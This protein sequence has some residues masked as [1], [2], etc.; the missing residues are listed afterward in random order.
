MEVIHGATESEADAQPHTLPVQLPAGR[1]FDVGSR[2]PG[3][4]LV[5]GH[6]RVVDGAA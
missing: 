6:S 1:A 5:G 3:A 2:Q 4:A